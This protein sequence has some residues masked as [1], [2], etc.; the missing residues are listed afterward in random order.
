LR[1]AVNLANALT[2]ADTIS[3]DSSVF[4][5]A[6][7][8]TLTAGQLVLTDSATTILGPGATLLTVNGNHKSRVILVQKGS[9][10]LS[11]LT[12]TGGS[13][14]VGGGLYNSGGTLSLTGCTVSGNSATFV[15]GN[16]GTYT[17]GGLYNRY[18]TLSLTDATIS[19]NSAYSDNG[20]AN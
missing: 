8:I 17:G 2:S 7:V 11:G 3:F 9:A 10:A 4:A 5:A 18:G 19:G 16:S 12:I 14:D 6:Q 1:Q 20:L 13:D 15:R